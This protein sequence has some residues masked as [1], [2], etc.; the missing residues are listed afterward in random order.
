M[1]RN[2]VQTVKKICI[3]YRDAAVAENI[4]SNIGSGKEEEVE[5]LID[6]PTDL[7]YYMLDNDQIVTLIENT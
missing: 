6:V 5:N 7:R 1:G 3:V 2:V 4:V